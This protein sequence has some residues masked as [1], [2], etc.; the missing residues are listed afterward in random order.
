MLNMTAKRTAT[1]LPSDP[2]EL[3]TEG[4]R[5]QLNASLMRMALLRRKAEVQ[6]AG[7]QMH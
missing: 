1:P 7:I 2:E 5:K 4:E 3:L 6:S